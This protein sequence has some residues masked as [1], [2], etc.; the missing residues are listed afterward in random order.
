MKSPIMKEIEKLAKEARVQEAQIR[1]VL[2][3]VQKIPQEHLLK[4]ATIEK[5]IKQTAKENGMLC[6]FTS[7]PSS[8]RTDFWARA[9][10]LEMDDKL[11]TAVQ[12]IGGVSFRR[13]IGRGLIVIIPSPA[14][15]EPYPND[16]RFTAIQGPKGWITKEQ[17]GLKDLE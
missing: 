13:P 1:C 15:E 11:C 7:P 8:S 3:K 4:C 10:H 5:A 16:S 6:Y 9:G 17:F 12:K 14:K 2:R